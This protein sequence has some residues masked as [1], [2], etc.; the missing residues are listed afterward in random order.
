MGD[1]TLCNVVKLDFLTTG[2][3]RAETR[4]EREPRNRLEQR[5]K[6]KIGLIGFSPPSDAGRHGMS[7][8]RFV[9]TEF[10][11]SVG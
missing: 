8:I 1:K 9:R 2:A 6:V 7:E 10:E 4:R 11:R 3:L 5:S